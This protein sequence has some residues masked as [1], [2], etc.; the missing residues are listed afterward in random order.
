[1]ANASLPGAALFLYIAPVSTPTLANTFLFLAA[2]HD[3]SDEPKPY[4]EWLQNYAHIIYPLLILLVVVLVVS[5]V[6]TALR[7]QDLAGAVKAEAKRRVVVEL[8]QQLQ[9]TTAE[10]LAKVV[11]LEPFRV[12]TLLEELQREGLVTSYTSS[13]RL[14]TWQI[15]GTMSRFR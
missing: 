7:T 11:G 1:M 9:G 14:T 10:A 8:R 3:A 12:V 2:S 5:A 6:V 13:D 15:K 4:F